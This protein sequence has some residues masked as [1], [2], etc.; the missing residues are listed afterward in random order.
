MY[1]RVLA[2]EEKNL[3]VLN[4]SP[5]SV[6]TDLLNT[7]ATQSH[8]ADLRTLLNRLQANR[9]VL[10]PTDTARGFIRIIERG[11]YKSGDHVGY[12]PN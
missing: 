3:L 9:T 12:T 4:Y 5:G 6:D 8:S 2:T 1:F 11:N 7:A 10:Q